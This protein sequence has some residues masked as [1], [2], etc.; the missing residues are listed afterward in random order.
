MVT[1]APIAEQAPSMRTSRERTWQQELE[2]SVEQIIEREQA[3]SWMAVKLAFGIR[4]AA[5]RATSIEDFV[6]QFA[7]AM[8]NRGPGLIEVFC[9]PQEGPT[10]IVCALFCQAAAWLVAIAL[11]LYYTIVKNN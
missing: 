3:G 9:N 10:G 5:S 2:S 4:V 1:P 7:S 6:Q 11:H 8:K